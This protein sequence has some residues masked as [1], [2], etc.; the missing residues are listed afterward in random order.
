MMETEFEFTTTVVGY[1]GTYRTAMI[2][3]PENVVR[4]LPKQTRIRTEGT[5]NGA[6]FALAILRQK[7]GERYFVVSAALRKAAR[8][9]D[10]EPVHV[11]FHCVDVDRL[12]LPEELQALLDVDPEMQAVWSTFTVGRQRGLA[13]YVSSAKSQDV[14]IRR[15]LELMRKAMNNE[16]EFQRTTR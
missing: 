6:P 14:R 5:M 10:G 2:V 3:V 13:H 12:V 15:A 4:T 7:T 1:N 11:K 16:L 9:K 8:V